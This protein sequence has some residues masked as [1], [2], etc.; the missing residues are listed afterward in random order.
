MELDKALAFQGSQV[1]RGGI[2]GLEAHDVG[3]F[4]ASR[5]HTG[6]GDAFADTVQHLLLA[7][8]EFAAHNLLHVSRRISVPCPGVIDAS[9]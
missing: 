6:I 1:V 5:C 4:R 2:L 9:G 3:N 8:S 7:I